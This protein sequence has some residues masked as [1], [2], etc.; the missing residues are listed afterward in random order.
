MIDPAHQPV[1]FTLNG[2]EVVANAGETI[3]QVA[4]R[5]GVEIPHL[6]YSPEPGYRVDGNCRACM[7]E[8][9]G[10][11]VLAPSC[12]RRPTPGMKVDTDSA[13]AR[14]AR[15]LVME[16]LLADMPP[17]DS[18]HDPDSKFWRWAGRVGV[19][20]SRFPPRE[21]PAPDLSHPAMAVHLD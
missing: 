19:T 6:C 21:A 5:E 3:W 11:R 1:A 10:E 9:A 15:V 14:S 16:L 4:R 17:R 20:S 12:V 8:V 18:A 13:R 7:V 2:R